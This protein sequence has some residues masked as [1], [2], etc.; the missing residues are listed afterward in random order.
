[1][2][3]VEQNDEAGTSAENVGSGDGTV[4]GERGEGS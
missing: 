4:V 3:E 1:M 2:P